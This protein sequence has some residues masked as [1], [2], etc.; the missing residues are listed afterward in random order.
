METLS[1]R[2]VE[3]FWDELEKM[4][5][6]YNDEDDREAR[7]ARREA[8]ALGAGTVGAIGAA[9]GMAYHKNQQ[10]LAREAAEE[11]AAKSMKG[12][13]TAAASQPTPEPCAQ[14]YASRPSHTQACTPWYEQLP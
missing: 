2:A 14:Q 4:S 13:G 9:G 3:S 12:R 10:R 7:R 6:A 1:V 5:Y 8:L 11:L